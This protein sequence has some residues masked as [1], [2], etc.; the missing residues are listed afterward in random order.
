MVGHAVPPSGGSVHARQRPAEVRGIRIRADLLR[1]VRQHRRSVRARFDRSVRRRVAPLPFEDPVQL[2]EQEIVQVIAGIA[3]GKDV[4]LELIPGR[5][6]PVRG[7]EDHDVLGVQPDGLL[8]VQ[9]VVR[10]HAN[11][12][13]ARI[14]RGGVHEPVDLQLVPGL[15]RVRVFVRIEIEP[16]P[17]AASR[18][19]NQCVDR[20]RQGHPGHVDINPAT[21]RLLVDERDETVLIT[22][23]RGEVQARV[24]RIRR[25]RPDR[26]TGEVGVVD[27][28]FRVRPDV[29]EGRQERCQQ[30]AGEVDGL[31][32]VVLEGHDRH[33]RR[34][35]VVRAG[36]LDDTLAGKRH[37]VPVAD[38]AGGTPAHLDARGR[39]VRDERGVAGVARVRAGIHDHANRHAAPRRADE[40]AGDPG[41][42]DGPDP[43]INPDRFLVY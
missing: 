29:V 12:D 24:D 15:L 4:R 19:P 16:F 20:P 11:L 2:V 34:R 31:V 23:S 13:G 1:R 6:R 26:G 30:L 14:A 41:I 27:V 18:G 5:I 32:L 25:M 9:S 17:N 38:A 21:G 7:A 37:Q 40:R 28:V 39:H 10:A 33:E 42:L 22:V 3:V 43:D 35:A 8:K 36:P